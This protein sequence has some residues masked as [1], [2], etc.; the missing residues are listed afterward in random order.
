MHPLPSQPDHRPRAA[1]GH[2]R[3]PARPRPA[4]RRLPGSRRGDRMHPVRR[5][6]APSGEDRAMSFFDSLWDGLGDAADDVGAAWSRGFFDVTES[7]FDLLGFETAADNLRRY[8]S[9]VGGDYTYSAEEMA[10]HPAF[11]EAVD[12]NRTNFESMTF[13]GRMKSK[14]EVNERLLNLNDGE[15]FDNGDHWDRA[16][17]YSRPSTY[18]AF[19]RFPVHS[20]GDFNAR[21]N[22]DRLMIT[23]TVESRMGGRDNDYDRFDFNEGQPGHLEGLSL[24]SIDKARPFNMRYRT[25]QDVEAE[26][27]YGRDPNN[28]A[29]PILTLSRA[30]WGPW[31]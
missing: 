18:L 31:R 29:R 8:R 30:T 9:G 3:L 24:E 23:G 27:Q 28:P 4:P 5:T 12:D 10:G 14:P 22:G 19:G 26:L 2:P 13:T 17:Q 21:R 15:S 11:Y 16:V 25:I 6:G 20:G 7:I 1:R